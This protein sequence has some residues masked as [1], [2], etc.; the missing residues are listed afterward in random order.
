[1]AEAALKLFAVF[2][3]N[4]MF[5][6]IE[7]ADRAAVIRRCYRPILDAAERFGL[8]LGFEAS[9]L[10]LEIARRLDPGFIDRLGELCRRGTVEFI[11]GGYAQLI[12]PLVSPRV[13][14]TNLAAGLEAARAILGVTPRL[15][16]PGEL[17][18]SAGLAGHYRQ[19]GFDGVILDFENPRSA[20]RL[21]AEAGGRVVRTVGPDGAS[22]PV[23]FNHCLAFQKF[24]RYAHGEMALSALL[25]YLAGKIGLGPVFSL[26]GNDAEIF[27]YRPGRFEAEAPL[28][29]EGEW[30]RISRLL[31]A[32]AGDPRF[33]LVAPSA[34]LAA[35]GDPGGL[36]E[37]ALTTATVP[38]AVKKQR[39]YNI[40][41]WAVTGRDD[42]RLNA[43][44]ALLAEGLPDPAP[45][46]PVGRNWKAVLRLFSSDHR[47]HLTQKRWR[48]LRR[49]AVLRQGLAGLEA[50][51]DAACPP[52][53]ADPAPPPGARCDGDR[54]CL[55]TPTVRAELLTRKGLAVESVTFA[56]LGDRPLA[57]AVG[58]GTFADIAL[59]ADFF[60]GHLVFEAPGRPKVTDL[61]P[62]RPTFGSHGEG[63]TAGFET[64]LGLGGLRKAVTASR[65]APRLDIVYDYTSQRPLA[66]S[67]RLFHVT[68]PPGAFD[69]GSLYYRAAQGGPPETFPLAGQDVDHGRAV[70]FLVSAGQGVGASDGVVD[71]GDRD[72]FLRAR[73]VTP[74]VR[75]LALVTCRQDEEGL[76]CRLAFS[77]LETDETSRPGGRGARRLCLRFSLE[78]FAAR[79]VCAPGRSDVEAGKTD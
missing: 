48:A 52:F 74:G 26:Y 17:A 57:G 11:G 77:I 34:A 62:C 75:P 33:A 78:A 71:I 67:L 27:D 21:P 40:S 73:V 41:R 65:T 15:A 53:P 70:S 76:F 31:Q 10:T 39:K 46:R 23:L 22:I 79:P 6:A 42:L 54:V 5:S 60:T 55:A 32:L 51:M 63:I 19:A 49:N 56:G 72:K 43:A 28:A 1:M 24:Q 3:C 61:V 44:C 4:L 47:T 12:G 45:G 66:G 37:L 18:W 38:I 14:R 35:G 20:C 68:L 13:N 29:P 2:H 8:P 69:P 25:D 7:E 36:P 16:F 50:A 9:G 58:H 64:R 59:A 30:R